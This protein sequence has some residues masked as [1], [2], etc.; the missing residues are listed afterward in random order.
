MEYI[1]TDFNYE[2][3]KLAFRRLINNN[4]L[5]YYNEIYKEKLILNQ[6]TLNLCFYCNRKIRN[7]YFTN[8]LVQ[9]KYQFGI[10]CHSIC[11]SLYLN[12]IKNIYNISVNTENYY[13]PP[14]SLF[15]NKNDLMIYLD[16]FIKN[17]IKIYKIYYLHE[18]IGSIK[19][20]IIGD[21]LYTKNFN[22]YEFSCKD[23]FLIPLENRVSNYLYSDKIKNNKPLIL[24]NLSS[25]L[26]NLNNNLFDYCLFCFSLIK[27]SKKYLRTKYDT[28]IGCFCSK[29]CKMNYSIYI[30]NHINL[31][32][33]YNFYLPEF[34]LI[35]SI[36]NDLLKI[37]KN[38][39]FR[40]LLKG[41]NYLYIDDKSQEIII[42][43]QIYELLEY[44][45]FY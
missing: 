35:K 40:Y 23:K 24:N 17:N 22:I 12:N 18:S 2:D 42:V 43:I 5:K 21:K 44:Q 7:N 4:N 27:T 37:I 38:S 13:L 34:H 20:K 45:L 29:L 1:N 28:F 9:I 14:I 6:L 26:N 15:T 32:Y 33:V 25:D 31:K 16:S 11:F 8:N 39:N 30:K 3:Q 41:F 19:V 10:Y 36:Y